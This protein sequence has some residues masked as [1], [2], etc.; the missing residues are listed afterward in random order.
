MAKRLSTR[1]ESAP[2]GQGQGSPD[3][4]NYGNRMGGEYPEGPG[5]QPQQRL[6]RGRRPGG[7]PHQVHQGGDGPA[8]GPRTTPP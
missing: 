1:C 8:V 4:A 7:E 5:P 6:A 3:G 2:D